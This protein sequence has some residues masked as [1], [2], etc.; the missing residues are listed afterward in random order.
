MNRKRSI[1]ALIQFVLAIALILI[2]NMLANSRIGGH[3]LYGALDLTEDG[4]YTLTDGTRQLLEGQEDVVFVRVL[5]EGE[6]PSGIDRLRK[7]SREILEDFRS[8][9]PYVEYEFSD[10]LAGSEEDV[11]QRLEAM[12][13]EGITPGQLDV[14]ETDSR[15]KKL[16]FPYAVFNRGDRQIVVNLLENDVPGVPSEVILN[17]AVALLEYKFAKAIQQLQRGYFPIVALTTGQGELPPIRTADLEK[18]LRENYDVGRLSLDSVVAIP[19]EVEALIIAK[20]TRP[21]SERNKFK[22]DQYVMNGGKILWLLDRVAVDLD[23]LQGRREYYPRPYEL[24]ID[25]LLFRYGV[26]LEDDLVLDLRCTR[27]PMATGMVGNTPQFELFRYPYH[28]LSL[29]RSNHP[30]VKSLEAVNLF[31]PSSI[32]LSPRTKTPVEKTILLMSSD[33]AR[34]QKLPVGLDFEFLQY[35]LDPSRFTT[36]SLVMGVLLEGVFPSMYENR[37]TADNLAVLDQVGVEYK[38]ESVPSRMIVVSDGDVAAN[39]VRSDGSVLPLG[40]NVFEQYQFSN[41]D[42]LVNALEYLLDESGVIQARGKDIKLRLLNQDRARAESQYWQLIN[43]V[44]PLLF[45]VLFGFLYN[46]L[47]RRRY[48]RSAAA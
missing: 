34:Y 2:V 40:V 42:F 24:N 10:P 8:V 25:D 33:A 27:I 20:P 3:R 30:I 17:N 9:S 39:P 31:Y 15:S 43:L 32:D 14:R 35:D 7:A 19:T 36:D 46:W 26:R 48:G 4:R 22:L 28:V 29:P 5:L 18:Q 47:R 38:A 16:F 37:L 12:K 45:L 44:L 23:S 13:E 11:R 1:T 6:F 21:F 41:K